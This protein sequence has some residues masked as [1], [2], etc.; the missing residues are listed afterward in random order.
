MTDAHI[1]IL[2]P[3]GSL[4]MLIPATRQFDVLD[5]HSHAQGSAQTDQDRRWPEA[6]AMA[7]KARAA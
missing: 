3:L 7:R 6:Q 4:A 1:S 2:L 5:A